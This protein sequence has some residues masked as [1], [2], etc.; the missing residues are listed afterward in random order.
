MTEVLQQ[1]CAVRRTKFEILWG[2]LPL[3]LLSFIFLPVS[4]LFVAEC[5]SLTSL[6]VCVLLTRIALLLL[7]VLNVLWLGVEKGI[8]SCCQSTRLQLQRILIAQPPK[9][10]RWLLT[11]PARRIWRCLIFFFFPL[12]L[13]WRFKF[14]ITQHE[15]Q[16]GKSK[17]E[18]WLNKTCHQWIL[19][20]CNRVDTQIIW[21]ERQR[22]M[23]RAQAF[24]PILFVPGPCCCYV[25]A[26][27]VLCSPV[28][29]PTQLSIR[30][31]IAQRHHQLC[32][33]LQCILKCN[34]QR[35]YWPS[36]VQSKLSAQY[37]AQ[38]E[39]KNTTWSLLRDP[40]RC[41]LKIV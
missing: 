35:A 37:K 34:R 17:S 26:A 10:S 12:T 23:R 31:D 41:T 40:L 2:F 16:N 14:K 25:S 21:S 20:L 8:V 7:N 19:A 32:A 24:N 29:T 6:A 27:T 9:I 18:I 39:K 38:S 3:P 13:F 30:S 5:I 22:I 1:K 11:S 33:R 15:K 28:N 4:Y 36:S